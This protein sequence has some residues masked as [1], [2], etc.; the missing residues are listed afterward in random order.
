MRLKFFTRGQIGL[1][2]Q[3]IRIRLWVNYPIKLK[4]NIIWVLNRTWLGRGW[5]PGHL[6]F[7]LRRSFSM[8]FQSRMVSLHPGPESTA[9]LPSW[10]WD[11]HL[12][13]WVTK[14]ILVTQRLS[15]NLAELRYLPSRKGRPTNLAYTATL[16][17]KAWKTCIHTGI[18]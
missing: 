5:W 15:I 8:G 4:G 10:R 18:S 13:Q 6:R 9:S 16:I 12:C 17:H 11:C 2:T 7:P 3:W 1:P 14:N